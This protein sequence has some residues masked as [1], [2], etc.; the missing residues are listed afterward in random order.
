MLHKQAGGQP[1]DGNLNTHKLSESP[2]LSQRKAL[3]SPDE[4]DYLPET[5]Q[6]EGRTGPGRFRDRVNDLKRDGL[7]MSDQDDDEDDDFEDI[8]DDEFDDEFDDDELE[9]DEEDDED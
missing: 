9:I 3:L 6:G 7:R 4:V 8:D 5:V 1:L 2:H